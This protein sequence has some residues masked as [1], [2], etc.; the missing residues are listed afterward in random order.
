MKAVPF[1]YSVGDPEFILY[2]IIAPSIGSHLYRSLKLAAQVSSLYMNPSKVDIPDHPIC[3]TLS[4]MTSLKSSVS[5]SPEKLALATELE[6]IG[7]GIIKS[8]IV[9]V[10]KEE[11]IRFDTDLID[12]RDAELDS[13][14][15]EF[16]KK[17]I[18]RKETI[19][20]RK[21]IIG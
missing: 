20:V 18:T 14:F 13:L 1:L 2:T 15:K 19:R 8:E 9:K 11:L 12:E 21:D 6:E 16:S 17:R 7:N 10:Q 5:T 4:W 3:L